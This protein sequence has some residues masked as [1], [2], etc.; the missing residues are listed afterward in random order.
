MLYLLIAG[1]SVGCAIGLR[2]GRMAAVWVLAGMWLLT[3]VA[4]SLPGLEGL[5]LGAVAVLHLAAAVAA[6]ANRSAAASL[7][8]GVARGLGPRAVTVA[9]VPQD[10]VLW[11]VCAGGDRGPPARGL[12]PTS[13]NY[14]VLRLVLGRRGEHRGDRHIVIVGPPRVAAAFTPTLPWFW[15]AGLVVGGV[16]AWG[17]RGAATGG[18]RPV[19]P[20]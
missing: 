15:R 3:L 18:C 1:A 20:R 8:P 17:S 9:R 14:S 4:V 6:L 2:A 11:V 13:G 12:G 19:A 7:G 16:L 10:W 5:G